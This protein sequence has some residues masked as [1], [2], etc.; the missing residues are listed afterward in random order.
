M[1]RGDLV[2]TRYNP[3]RRLLLAL[4]G[5]LVAGMLVAWGYGCL[6]GAAGESALPAGLREENAALRERAAELESVNTRL[7]E[8]LA[9]DRTAGEVRDRA[10]AELRATIVELQSRIQSLQ[11]ELSFYRSIVSPQESKAGL[12]VHSLRLRRGAGENNYYYD[13][14]L[15][16][17]SDSGDRLSGEVR[18]AVHG[19]QAGSPR[20]YDLAA[21][22]PDSAAALSFS[23][24]YFQELTGMLT[25]PDGFAPRRLEVE[26]LPQGAKTSGV[27]RKYRWT[28]LFG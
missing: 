18:I 1:P 24:R 23:F 2:V 9:L 26:V 21:M 13:L 12:R 16:Q 6:S 10:N 15:V 19:E 3:R 5:L 22:S 20:R 8:Q 25:L 28:A 7:R 27:V 17:A 4:V 11:E 14:V